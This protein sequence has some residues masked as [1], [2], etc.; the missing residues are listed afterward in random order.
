VIAPSAASLSSSSRRSGT[1][2]RELG[3]A[4]PA[5]PLSDEEVVRAFIDA[6]REGLIELAAA[7]PAQKAAIYQHMGLRL[8]YHP[9]RGV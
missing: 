3:E 1:A 4:P 8:T 9:D 7:S 5:Q 6:V 2:Q